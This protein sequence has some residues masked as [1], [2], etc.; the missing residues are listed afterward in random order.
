ADRA[1]LVAGDAR[2]A[3]RLTGAFRRTSDERVRLDARA[4]FREVLRSPRARPVLG[5]VGAFVLLLVLIVV[6]RGGRSSAP[7]ATAMA[8]PT[9]STAAFAQA[10]AGRP[11]SPGQAAPATGA[12]RT[13]PTIEPIVEPMKHVD[14][15]AAAA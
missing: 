10:S 15:T 5:G 7:T 1:V 12:A 8:A 6:L 14:D 2:A 13:G 9:D 4:R 11:S 3:F